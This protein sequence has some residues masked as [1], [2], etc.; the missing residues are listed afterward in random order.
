ME[1]RASRCHW[2]KKGEGKRGKHCEAIK[3]PPDF[4][5][6][7]KISHN[8]VDPVNFLRNSMWR[9]SVKMGLKLMEGLE[10][11]RGS[12]CTNVGARRS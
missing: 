11:S 10:K 6:K 12:L 4:E 9:S 3:K 5:W 1:G 8:L 7:W 2:G